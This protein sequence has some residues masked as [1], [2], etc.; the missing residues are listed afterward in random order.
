MS[1]NHI[2]V[3]VLIIGVVVVVVVAAVTV[4]V[5]LVVGSGRAAPHLRPIHR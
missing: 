5:V 4:A 3:E 2:V 1:A